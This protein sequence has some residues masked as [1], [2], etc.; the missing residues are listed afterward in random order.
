[1]TESRDAK[2]RSRPHAARQID[3]QPLLLADLPLSL[4]V[5]T[6]LLDYLA[7]TIAALARAPNR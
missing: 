7:P 5:G 1:L 2:D 6:E 3:L 4:A